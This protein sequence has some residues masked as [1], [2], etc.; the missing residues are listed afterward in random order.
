[1]VSQAALDPFPCLTDIKYFARVPVREQIDST[2]FGCLHGPA[3]KNNLPL[4]Q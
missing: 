1:M 2:F 4:C 3:L